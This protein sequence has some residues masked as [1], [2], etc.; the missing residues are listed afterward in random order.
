[1]K[2]RL[3]EIRVKKGISQAELF[4]RSGL[5][6]SAVS[7]IERGFWNPRPEV[8]RRLARALHVKVT[9][10]FPEDENGIN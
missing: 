6:P 5:W 2:N 1:M 9:D 3:R 8:K 7:F 4:G 10:L